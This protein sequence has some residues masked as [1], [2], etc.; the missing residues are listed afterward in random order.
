MSS[1]GFLLKRLKIFDK[2]VERKIQIIDYCFPE[3]WPIIPL[4][5]V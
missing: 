3:K 4:K 1:T 5:N 2:T